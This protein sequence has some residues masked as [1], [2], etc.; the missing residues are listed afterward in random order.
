MSSKVILIP[1]KIWESQLMP[2]SHSWDFMKDEFWIHRWHWSFKLI[3]FEC[4]KVQAWQC[5][6]LM[7]SRCWQERVTS[8]Q[9]FSFQLSLF[10]LLFL[11]HMHARRQRDCMETLNRSHRDTFSSGHKRVSHF[12]MF[13]TYLLLEKILSVFEWAELALL[14]FMLHPLLRGLEVGNQVM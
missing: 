12:L 14:A 1:S 5:L 8:S 9:S 3:W 4:T 10:A 7:W 6:L 13:W 11:E 2:Y